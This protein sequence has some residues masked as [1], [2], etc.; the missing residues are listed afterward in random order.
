M[1]TAGTS[2]VG[3]LG[4]PG[5]DCMKMKLQAGDMPLAA[6]KDLGAENGATGLTGQERG[7]VE[8]MAEKNAAGRRRV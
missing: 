2:S 6:L 1:R 4:T 8:Y 7:L 5:A 3:R